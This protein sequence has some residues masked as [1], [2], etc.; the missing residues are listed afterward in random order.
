M[1]E[2][3]WVEEIEGLLVEGLRPVRDLELLTKL[4]DREEPLP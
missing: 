1:Y 3:L 4:A 2:Q